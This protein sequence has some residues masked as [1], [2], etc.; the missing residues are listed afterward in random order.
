MLAAMTAGVI[1]GC[2]GT[3]T[4]SPT[5]SGVVRATPPLAVTTTP[6]Q[7]GRA[8]PGLH[9]SPD[10]YP[11]YVCVRETAGQRTQTAI[12]FTPQVAALCARHPE[13][14]PC[15]YEREACRRSGGRVFTA[16]GQEITR[17][18]EDEYDRRVARVR[19]RAN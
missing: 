16:S 5:A 7:P 9:S 17:Q 3:T 19:F 15:Q 14:G 4:Q 1:W 11:Q 2:G 10:G 13:M 12:E 8:S 6:A 18:I